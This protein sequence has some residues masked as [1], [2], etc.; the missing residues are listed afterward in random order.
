MYYQILVEIVHI[1]IMVW[2]VSAPG[3]IFDFFCHNQT[4]YFT[5]MRAGIHNVKWPLCRK[6]AH[7]RL[8]CQLN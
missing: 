5:Y 1:H 3:C 8:R 6:L 4:S 7:K 2:F